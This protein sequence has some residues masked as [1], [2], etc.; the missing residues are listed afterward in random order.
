ML[1][2]F[3]IEGNLDSYNRGLLTL[4]LGSIESKKISDNLFIITVF[5][6]R[7][8]VGQTLEKFGLKV[9]GTCDWI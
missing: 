9:I 6:V 7:K 3:K 2:T 1:K 5:D 4:E 8:N